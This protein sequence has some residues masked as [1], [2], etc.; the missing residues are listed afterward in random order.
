MLGKLDRDPGV[1]EGEAGL[2][3]VAGR[4]QAALGVDAAE[5]HRPIGIRLVLE[6]IPGR[7]RERG[8]EP[9]PALHGRSARRLAKEGVELVQVD[10]CP[11]QVR[12]ISARLGRDQPA[13][14]AQARA[15]QR[16]VAFDRR[17]HLTRRRIAPDHL[18]ELVLGQRTA[19]LDK[20]RL[21]QLP[22]LHATEVARAQAPQ[23]DPHLDRA[24][25]AHGD[26]AASSM[27]LATGPYRCSAHVR[28]PTPST[29]VTARPGETQGSHDAARRK[30]GVLLPW[31]CE[32][33]HCRAAHARTGRRAGAR[34]DTA[35]SR[36]N[37]RS[38][39]ARSRRRSRSSWT[40]RSSTARGR[41]LRIRTIASRQRQQRRADCS[42]PC[43]TAASAP[44]AP[45]PTRG[46]PR[47]VQC[48]SAYRFVR[49]RT[50]S[51]RARDVSRSW[52]AALRGRVRARRAH[53]LGGPLPRRLHMQRECPTVVVV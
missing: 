44:P 50:S 12:A 38:A 16:H 6:H 23:V 27:A 42:Y 22:R 34:G 21:Q 35:P 32:R 33:V 8:L 10:P 7:D 11:A 29:A 4:L 39:A 41:P 26:H 25:Q 36:R 5:I 14:L 13:G 40:I 45:T 51:S 43:K 9:L 18:S 30:P 1:E 53:R 15:Q 17:R 47:W 52:L 31:G 48:A 46:R 19:A 37:R 2:G 24:E 49:V 20:Q 3:Q 28:V